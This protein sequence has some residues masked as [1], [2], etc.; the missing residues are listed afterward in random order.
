[1]TK[2]KQHIKL[3]SIE[4][5]NIHQVPDQYFSKLNADIRNRIENEKTAVKKKETPVF[6]LAMPV[7]I[8][9]ILALAYFLFW[10]PSAVDSGY[11]TDHALAEVSV[12]DILDYLEDIELSED[13]IL[14]S[15]DVEVLANEVIGEEDFLDQLDVQDM[16]IID[17]MEDFDLEDYNL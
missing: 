12:D 13:E 5:G 8:A 14:A 4:K 11:N 1:M 7:A 9:A 3:E 16:D 6:K 15:I 10:T 2:K 17:A